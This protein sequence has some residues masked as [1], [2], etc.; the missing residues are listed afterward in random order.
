MAQ[1]AYHAG[2][3]QKVTIKLS[4]F[5]NTVQ[6]LV[7]KGHLPSIYGEDLISLGEQALSQF[8]RGGN[9]STQ[10]RSS[11]PN[12]PTG[13]DG[14]TRTPSSSRDNTTGTQRTRTADTTGSNR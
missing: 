11:E 1:V 4:S 3:Y 10:S 2:D 13:P 12:S 6:W 7:D 8:P 9:G 14:S 5:V